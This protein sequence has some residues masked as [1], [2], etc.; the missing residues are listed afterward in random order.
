MSVVDMRRGFFKPVGVPH[1][2]DGGPAD[3]DG[4]RRSPNRESGTLPQSWAPSAGACVIGVLSSSEG[5][6]PLDVEVTL[7]LLTLL[8][9]KVVMGILIQHLMVK[10]KQK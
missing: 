2:V 1:P 8:S 4:G 9:S 6:R 7:L 10:T 3:P 5:G